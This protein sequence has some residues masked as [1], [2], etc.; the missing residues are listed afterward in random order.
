MPTSFTKSNRNSFANRCP[1]R[2]ESVQNRIENPPRNRSQIDPKSTPESSKWVPDRSLGAQGAQRGSPKA[3]WDAL[4]ALE[5][6]KSSPK[7]PKSSPRGP[8]SDRKE[9][10][11]RPR[12][13]TRASRSES[14]RHRL[15]G[16]DFGT[17]NRPKID[18]KSPSAKTWPIWLSF[19]GSGVL[20]AP[21]SDL[22]N[23]KI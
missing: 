3:S 18:E 23:T 5:G 21:P 19:W 11:S 14:R 9:S 8:K 16:I 1:H 15:F 7:G 2:F 17:K 10:K 6:P 12:G 20:W 13:R 22:K 4:G